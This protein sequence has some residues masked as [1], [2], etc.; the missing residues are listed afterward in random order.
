MVVDRLTYEAIKNS[1][2]LRQFVYSYEQRNTADGQ[3]GWEGFYIRGKETFLELFY[4]QERYEVVGLSGIGL[5]CDVK[6]DLRKFFI[7]YFKKQFPNAHYS[8]FERQGVPWF[9]Y[10]SV[11]GSYYGEGHSFWVME[12][13]PACFVDNQNDISRAHYNARAFDPKKPLIDITGFS[14]ALNSID[15]NTISGYLASTGMSSP[16]S[17]IYVN[18]S[19]VKIEV[20]KESKTQKGIYEITFSLTNA[21]F[22][23]DKIMLGNSEIVVNQNKAIWRFFRREK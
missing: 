5:G 4:P 1:E 13:A 7:D 15:Q 21:S 18:K 3:I 11:G 14:L 20:A 22:S 12:Y 19:G 8:T 17:N 9:D 2:F 23:V 6:G 10:V 16:R